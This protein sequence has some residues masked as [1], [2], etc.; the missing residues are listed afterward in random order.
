LPKTAFPGR[1][2][3]RE[4]RFVAGVA[5]ALGGTGF[6]LMLVLDATLG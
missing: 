2:L 6:A 3:G 4:I 1:G 5:I